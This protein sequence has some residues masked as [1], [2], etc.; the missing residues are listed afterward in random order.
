MRNKGALLF[1]TDVIN[2]ALMLGLIGTGVVIKW[3]LP[4]GSG[5]GRAGGHR[6]ASVFSLMRHDWG[7]VHFGIAAALVLGIVVHLLLHAGWI[8][9]G[10][11]K[12]L[13]LGRK[14]SGATS[15]SSVS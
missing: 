2:A 7:E 5:G 12:F 11:R 9:A 10:C 3:V 6:G 4:A 8:A 13:H 15:V 14:A 1:W